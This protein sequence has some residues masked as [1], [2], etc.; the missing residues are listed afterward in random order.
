MRRDH[1]LWT[2]A[3]AAVGALSLAVLCSTSRPR[4][5]TLSPKRLVAL[6]AEHGEAWDSHPTRGGGLVL[7]RPAD[8]TPWD[9]LLDLADG[10]AEPFGRERG[11]LHVI[12]DDTAATNPIYPG[13]CHLPLGRLLVRGSPEELSRL[14]EVVQP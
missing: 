2:A 8:P 4:V 9:Q 10:P 7:K 11:R 14:M 13:P 6:L 1:V 12:A 5:G 3:L